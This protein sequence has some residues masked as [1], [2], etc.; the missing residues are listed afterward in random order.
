MNLLSKTFYLLLQHK[1]NRKMNE[2]LPHDGNSNNIEILNENIHFY[3]TEWVVKNLKKNKA[4]G[5]D[6]IQNEVLQNLDI[7]NHT[8][9]LTKR[10]GLLIYYPP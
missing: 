4:P 9:A 6:D 10:F 3:E 2:V 8:L 1:S 7:K 5:P